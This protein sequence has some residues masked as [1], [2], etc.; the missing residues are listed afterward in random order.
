MTV[1]LSL[2]EEADWGL[3]SGQGSSREEDGAEGSPRVR[4]AIAPGS[5]PRSEDVEGW[6]GFT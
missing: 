1:T 4:G 5:G 6:R 2:P 3:S